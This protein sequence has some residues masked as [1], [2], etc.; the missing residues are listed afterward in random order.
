MP[1]PRIT[2]GLPVYKGA[3]LIEKALECLQK[4]T[5]GNF[6][7]IIS[8]DNG[9]EETADACQGFLSDRR[10]RMVVQQTR[11]D[12]V[13]NFN[14]LLQQDLN[15]FF[16]YRQHDDTTAPEFFETLLEAADKDPGAAD[17]YSDCQYFG[18]N[19]RVEITHSIEGEMLERLLQFIERLP[20]A[21]G[22]PVRG[23]IRSAA[24]RHAGLVRTD[25]FRAALQIHGWLAKLLLW[26]SFKR[27]ARP[28]YYKLDHTNSFTRD[29]WDW[30]D[31]RRRAAWATMFTGLLEAAIPVCRTSEE[32]FFFQKTIF[33]RVTAY[34]YFRWDDPGTSSQELVGD[35]LERIKNEGNTCL[36]TE[37]EIPQ[38]L[39]TLP[40]EVL[41]IRASERSRLRKATLR[42]RQRYHLGRIIYQTSRKRRFIYQI[43]HL[44]RLARMM[45]RSLGAR[46]GKFTRPLY[47]PSTECPGKV[48]CGDQAQ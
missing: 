19:N 47:R 37:Q 3:G 8:V 16:C 18:L 7:A 2:V 41:E 24:I 13:G 4:Q 38:I 15:E 17:I 30:P 5:F 25:E 21:Q 12:W 1:T 14:W 40:D 44:I 39:K 34:P 33:G 26:G 27:V 42:I 9:D 46:Y 22:P 45:S 43:R 48:S 11:L 29:Y 36:L 23:L 31:D 35:C 20:R 10:F 32:R 28:L 6:E